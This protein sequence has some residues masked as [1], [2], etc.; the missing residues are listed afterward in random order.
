MTQTYP[1]NAASNFRSGNLVQGQ[2]LGATSTA[3]AL[4]ANNQ[5]VNFN[6]FRDTPMLDLIFLN[7]N[8][9]T[10]SSRV[11]T[12]PN[13]QLLGQQLTFV[14]ESGSGFTATFASG[15]NVQLTAPWV[16]VQYQS[17]SIIWDG[18]Y[19]VELSRTPAASIA[20][21]SLTATQVAAMNGAAISL[22][23]A[24]GAGLMTMVD[25]VEMFYNRV[26]SFTSGGTVQLQYATTPTPIILYPATLLTAGSSVHTVAKPTVYGLDAT[27]GTSTGFVTKA[28]QAVQITNNT[29][30]F[31][32]G[33]GS[34]LEYAIRYH[35]V[36]LQA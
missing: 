31:A 2:P 35:T 17:L 9:T 23:P 28:N 13:G 11:F 7:S 27:T 34:V 22:I 25:E 20:T 18:Q 10:A 36:T 14:F 3:V 29:G 6:P 33:V 12:I 5:L 26:A 30:A 21:G 15:T 24:P 1:S 32:G 16:P 19:W 8:S 4:S